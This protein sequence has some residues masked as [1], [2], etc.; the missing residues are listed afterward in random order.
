MPLFCLPSSFPSVIVLFFIFIIHQT[1]PLS[2][3]SPSFCFLFSFV[4]ALIIIDPCLGAM[5]MMIRGIG[6]EAAQAGSSGGTS[7][8]RGL[9]PAFAAAESE[10][11][12]QDANNEGKRGGE[13]PKL[14]RRIMI[15][16]IMMMLS[17]KNEKE[18]GSCQCRRINVQ[19]WMGVPT[20][21]MIFFFPSSFAPSVVRSFSF[22]LAVSDVLSCLVP[23]SLFWRYCPF[24]FLLLSSVFSLVHQGPTSWLYLPSLP[25]GRTLQKRLSQK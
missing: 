6:S 24:A 18:A 20:V 13:P 3:P 23:F 25:S 4:S 7:S 16:P 21:S 12:M 15:P 9:P 17:F 19:L 11:M 1:L 22:L 14:G 2:F 8:G 5:T 10:M